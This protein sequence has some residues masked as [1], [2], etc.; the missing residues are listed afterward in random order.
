LYA[1][2][3]QVDGQVLLESSLGNNDQAKADNRT[4]AGRDR[5][6]ILLLGTQAA[7]LAPSGSL[8]SA[9]PQGLI[10][11]IIDRKFNQLLLS[12]GDVAE[13]EFRVRDRQ[14]RNVDRALYAVPGDPDTER[15]HTEDSR[16]ERPCRQ[17]RAEMAWF[18][19]M[20]SRVIPG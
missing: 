2:I 14:T 5:D 15:G 13:I 16:Q 8:E 12:D 9:N 10:G 4:P 17:K 11:R 20:E 6:G 18:E 1:G 19:H 7:I 3:F